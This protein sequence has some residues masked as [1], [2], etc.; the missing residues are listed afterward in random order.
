MCAS[1]IEGLQTEFGKTLGDEDMV[2]LAPTIGT[3]NFVVNMLRRANK[4]NLSSP[5]S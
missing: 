4:A 1:V 2:I 5:V 3:G